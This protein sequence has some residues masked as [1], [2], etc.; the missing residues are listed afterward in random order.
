MALPDKIFIYRKK[1]LV[2]ILIIGI[3]GLVVYSNT[4]NVPFIFDDEFSI[5]RN[6]LIR[7]LG[8]F[9]FKQGGYSDNPGRYIGYL[10]FAL[11]YKLGGLA[12]TGYHIFN[13]IIH[14][15]NALLIYA[16]IILTFRTPY[17]KDSRLVP[18]FDLIAFFAAILF[19]VHPVQ[20]QAVTY[21]VQRLASLAT[22]FYLMALVLYARMRILKESESRSNKKIFMLYVL[23]LA[24]IVLAMKTKEIAFTLPVILTLYEFF[25]FRSAIRKRLI[26]L[27]PV[28]LTLLIIPVSILNVHKPVG[29]IISDVSEAT[30][31]QASISRGDYLLTQFSVIVTYIRLLFFPAD[32]N[33]DYDYP[34]YHSLF[35]PRVLVSFLALLSL[36]CISMFLLV[37]SR[38]GNDSGNRLIAF[39][40]FWF[41]ITLSVES[42]VIPIADVIYEHR[43]YL[44]SIGFF[45]ALV[46]FLMLIKDRLENRGLR[47]SYAIMPALV[48]AVLV[49]SIAT[50]ARNNIWGDEIRFWEDVVKKSP[51]IA[52]THSNLGVV[53][54]RKN[55]FEEAIKEF[56][57]AVR[58]DSFYPVAHYNLG[59][60]Y[61]KQGRFEEATE[62]LKTAIKLSSEYAV[63]HQNL[64]VIYGIQG[65]YEEAIGELQI[66]IKLNPGNA[67]IYYNFGEVFWRIG[68]FDEAAEKYRTAI[69]INPDFIEAHNNLG[70]IYGREGKFIEALEEF[71]SV[72][73]I[74]PDDIRAHFN[75][76]II[77]KKLG[78]FEE[79][80]RELQIADKLKN[81]EGK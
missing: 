23:S 39:G 31:A 62:E 75:M 61:G 27:I 47:A 59:N 11:N 10:T 2:Q 19:V 16:F 4:F 6:P 26:Y 45:I 77:Y 69:R 5:T 50:Y 57:T 64:G 28:I 66:A 48:I 49:L 71:Q 46:A 13:L 3:L 51:L 25:F 18:F 70:A 14:I 56:K 15:A 72:A 58:L 12:V 63:P 55:R 35:T 20:T 8:N 54:G 32:Q 37:K 78:R 34:I 52:R 29:A 73:K 24:T 79:A 65:R 30:N 9:F 7:N 60:I 22:M 38:K 68:Y 42:S 41:F 80:S 36:F 74:K 76:G 53:Y 17:I 43:V 21:T 40:I 44:P 33:L 67:S 1:P 81:I